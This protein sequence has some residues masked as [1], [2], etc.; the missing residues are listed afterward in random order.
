MLTIRDAFNSLRRITFRLRIEKNDEGA[1]EWGTGF[2]V[3]PEG[4]ALTA[5]HNLP[6]DVLEAGE[7]R[8]AGFYAGREISLECLVSNSLREE[9]GDVAVLK[10]SDGPA[11][12]VDYIEI[13]LLDQGSSP[14]HRSLYWAGRQVCAF[15][16]PFEAEGLGE[17]VVDGCI[18]TLQPLQVIDQVELGGCGPGITGTVEWLR[19]FAGERARQLEGI[20]GAPVLDRETG[21]VVAV[22]HRYDPDRRIIYIT[23]VGRLARKWPAMSRFAKPVQ[24]S[25]SGPPL[26]ERVLVAL[27]RLTDSDLDFRKRQMDKP[28]E[29][30]GREWF[31][32]P[33]ARCNVGR[34]YVPREAVLA[35][36]TNWLLRTQKTYMFV[37][38][39]SGIGKTNFVFE[40]IECINRTPSPLAQQAV[41]VLPLGD[42]FPD[43]SFS[44]NL[45]L[46]LPSSRVSTDLNAESLIDLIRNGKVLLVLDGLDEFVRQHTSKGCT[47]F[48][49]ELQRHLEPGRS[50][51]IVMCRD[52]I[53][54]R[55]QGTGAFENNKQPDS[56]GISP[57]EE[58]EVR[59]ALEMRLGRSSAAYATI[60]ANAALLRIASSP[61]LLEMMCAIGAND[62]NE[63]T[64]SP[65]E[66]HLYNLWFDKIIGTSGNGRA[67]LPREM[68]DDTRAKV[69][70]IAELMLDARSDLIS[71]STLNASG[72]P[73]E[74]LQTL[75]KAAVGIGIF[76][77]ETGDEW[78]FV[79]DSFREFALAKKI[80]TELK[81]EAYDLLARTTK[82]DYV[83]AE[84][85]MFLLGLFRS[86]SE[87]FRKLERAVDV[88]NE[89]VA[90]WDKLLWNV[91]E[92]VGSIGTA[93]EERFI[94]L[95]VDVLC[96]PTGRA[97]RHEPSYRTRYNVVRCLE[98]L[99]N[100]APRP[101]VEHVMTKGWPG[102]ANKK[103]F[104]AWAIR[105]FH[106][107]SSRPGCF[108]PMSYE[109]TGG[110]RRQRKVSD[111]LLRCVENLG[112]RSLDDEATHL[113]I[114]CTFALIRWLHKGHVS[115]VKKLLRRGD[116]CS[117]SRGNLFQAFLRFDNPA[118]FRD[119]SALFEGMT[120]AFCEIRQNMVS[121][122]FVFRR[123][124]FHEHRRSK[125]DGLVC[126]R[127]SYE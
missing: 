50:R 124:C 11:H 78:G 115:R 64:R 70:K 119:C 12:G 96:L 88:A 87:L 79:H 122:D 28:G 89:D 98:R 110:N 29:D 113:E 16:F 93:S 68:I 80:W 45:E 15:G 10:W 32:K 117:M 99:H 108:P 20:S 56:T 125:I 103:H 31:I 95:A 53:H 17:R 33:L 51:V 100:S 82:L 38:G 67:S 63:L 30:R 107:P 55:L 76:I 49:L 59:A 54:R 84:F 27:R 66:G 62:W 77:K 3:S 48:F 91:F 121:S 86:K 25:F 101:Y 47:D 37:T 23:E 114:N 44:E 72:I 34:L 43:K 120:L 7:G 111:C 127:C 112:T 61:L 22:E 102:R 40:L 46:Q 6:R 83:G 65:T 36:V 104:G 21:Q 35:R 75:T 105:G 60:A 8:I 4:H 81:D 41:F 71:E 5:F 94:D 26:T 106:M 123:V 39:P 85:Q 118:I 92:T 73:L 90:E 13:A 97:G 9:E 18:D 52:H 116:L 24:I 74:R 109:S 14:Q 1:Y 19:F 126:D 58:S 57:L 42:C 2:F 69:E